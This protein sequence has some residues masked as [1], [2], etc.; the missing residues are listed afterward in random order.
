[1]RAHSSSNSAAVVRWLRLKIAATAPTADIEWWWWCGGGVVVGSTRKSGQQ[2]HHRHSS[3]ARCAA[4]RWCGGRLQRWSCLGFGWRGG[5][6]PTAPQQHHSTTATCLQCGQQQHS[7]APQQMTR[8][9]RLSSAVSRGL[10]PFYMFGSNILHVVQDR[11]KWETTTLFGE[12]SKDI[13][14]RCHCM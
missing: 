9:P 4:L 3:A 1:M 5:D 7:W 11:Y 6:H 14:P 10:L 8:Y 13:S 12:S 2:R